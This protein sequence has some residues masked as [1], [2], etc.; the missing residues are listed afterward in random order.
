MPRHERHRTGVFVAA[1]TPCRAHATL[2]Q[3]VGRRVA[4]IAAR[5]DFTAACDCVLI[6]DLVNGTDLRPPPARRSVRHDLDRPR[7][8]AHADTWQAAGFAVERGD[9]TR[10]G[11]ASGQ[12]ISVRR[13]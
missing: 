5:V 1:R 8:Q 13:P 2:V 9:R 4:A 12:P 7:P 3:A 10:G 6:A 11:L